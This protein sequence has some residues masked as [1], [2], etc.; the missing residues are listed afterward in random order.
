MSNTEIEDLIGRM[1]ECRL[2]NDRAQLVDILHGLCT[3]PTIDG[4]NVTLVL[5]GILAYD[6]GDDPE[7]GFHKIEAQRFEPDGTLRDIS[8]NE[9]LPD[10]VA[11]FVQMVVA[12]ANG[13]RGMARDLFF[14]HVGTDGKKLMPLLTLALNEVTHQNMECSCERG[15]DVD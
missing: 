10:Y 3:G 15:S 9:A 2:S 6:M 5:A 4:F 14:A 7:G 8:I 12:V 1:V 11:T 13:D